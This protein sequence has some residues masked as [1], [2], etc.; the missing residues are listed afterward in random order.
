MIVTTKTGDQGTTE[1][2]SG[3]ISKADPLLEVLGDLDE[4]SADCLVF[5][6][7]TPAYR[8]VMEALVQDLSAGCAELAGYGEGRFCQRI[9]RLELEMK[10]M[11]KDGSKFRFH[12]PLACPSSALFN[13][14]RAVSRR[15]E[16][17]WWGL[18]NSRK[19]NPQLGIYLNRISDY[20]FALQIQAAVDSKSNSSANSTADSAM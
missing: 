16:R 6:S 7:L 11:L 8:L 3:R 20:F 1:I 19:T 13:R 17:H 10:E 2:Q 15:A 4:L 9:E 14:L 12:Y 18:Q 5:A